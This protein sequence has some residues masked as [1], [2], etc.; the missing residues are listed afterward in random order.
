MDSC[1]VVGGD[2]RHSV[3]D[4]KLISALFN[5]GTTLSMMHQPLLFIIAA[6]CKTWVHPS[7]TVFLFSAGP[8]SHDIL[9]FRLVYDDLLLDWATIKQKPD[10]KENCIPYRCAMIKAGRTDCYLYVIGGLKEGKFTPSCTRYNP[11]LNE[12]SNIADMNHARADHAVAYHSGSDSIYA[13]GG[14]V[15]AMC[16][17][18]SIECNEWKEQAMHPAFVIYSS[19]AVRSLTIFDDQLFACIN[20]GDGQEKTYQYKIE[21]GQ[22]T[23]VA[24]SLFDSGSHAERGRRCKSVVVHKGGKMIAI[25]GIPSV[26][27]WLVCDGTQLELSIPLSSTTPDHWALTLLNSC[28]IQNDEHMARFFCIFLDKDWKRCSY[29][30]SIPSVG[31]HS[32]SPIISPLDQRY[33]I[34]FLF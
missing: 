6:Y 33:P 31:D 1:L 14:G 25:G 9:G 18:Y 34:D 17:S 20:F 8:S 13:W 3:S 22:L 4:E 21:P 2:G 15:S 26:A 10:N 28:V 16:D 27:C 7:N 19:T 5:T 23:S 24:D 29:I 30:L 11:A 32:W 12:W